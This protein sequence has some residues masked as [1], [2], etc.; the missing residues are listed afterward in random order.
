M[1]DVTESAGCDTALVTGGTSGLGLAMAAALAEAGVRVA[2]TGRSGERAAAAAAPLP[3]AFGVAMDVRDHGSVASAVAT[4]WSR[5]GGI[6]LLVNNAGIGMRTVNPRFL[7]E[8]RGFWTVPADGFRDVIA[9]NLTG[10]FLVAREVTPRMLDAGDGRIVNVS[11]N[12]TTMTRAGFVP[13]GPSRAGAESLSRIMAA[14]DDYQTF[15]G[16][17]GAESGFVPVSA[18]SPSLL[19]QQIEVERRDKGNDKPP[20]LPA[21]ALMRP[22]APMLPGP[23]AP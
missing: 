8:P 10:Y 2:I 14:S 15:N 18:T 20:L 19:V 13:Y 21:P 16:Y 7:T 17:C 11:M 1:T 5:L 4:V 3:G 12:H 6:D 23:G 22:Q 9:T